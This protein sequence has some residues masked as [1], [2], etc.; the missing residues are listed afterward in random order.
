MRK[1]GWGTGAAVGTAWVGGAG[2][3]LGPAWAGAGCG[4]GEIGVGAAWGAGA[5]GA[6]SNRL[7]S[8]T[9]FCHLSQSPSFQRSMPAKWAPARA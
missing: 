9:R 7:R 3:A 2:G 8:S 5:A 4:A 6:S 1:R